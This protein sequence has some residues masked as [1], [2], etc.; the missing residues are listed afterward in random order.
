LPA[1]FSY[2][3]GTPSPRWRNWQT[4]ETQNLESLRWRVGSIP[5]LGI[6]D[7][8][9]TEYPAEKHFILFSSFFLLLPIFRPSPLFLKCSFATVFLGF[10]PSYRRK[11]E[12]IKKIIVGNW[13]PA[14]AGKTNLSLKR[15]QPWSNAFRP[16]LNHK[17]RSTCCSL[18]NLSTTPA[19]HLPEQCGTPVAVLLQ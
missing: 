10:M 8:S 13:F 14:F 5:T 3:K 16:P 15:K 1:V 2:N 18:F 19:T 12:S 11:P 7:N 9:E 6:L 4:R 17:R